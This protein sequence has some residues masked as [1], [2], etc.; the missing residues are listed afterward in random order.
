MKALRL[1]G[2]LLCGLV[3]LAFGALA[4]WAAYTVLGDMA[5]SFRDWWHDK[6]HHGLTELGFGALVVIG[7]VS[8][9]ICER[10][11]RLGYKLE[12]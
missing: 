1:I 10:L 5:D 12:A 7:F 6:E 4:A 8:A 9:Y 2:A 3:G 11:F